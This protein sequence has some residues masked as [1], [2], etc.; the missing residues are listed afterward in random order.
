MTAQIIEVIS[1]ITS[2]YSIACTVWR[3]PW[4]AK[5]R[6]NLGHAEEG[7]RPA[8]APKIAELLSGLPA[9]TA[10]MCELPDGTRLT[11]WWLQPPL[12]DA[13]SEESGRC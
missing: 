13:G 11:A 9:G 10:V 7:P 4:A 12:A 2:V 5:P 8:G 6:T 3:C 1:T